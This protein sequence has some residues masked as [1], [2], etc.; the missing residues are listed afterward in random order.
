MAGGHNWLACGR[1]FLVC[2]GGRET[3][4]P[5]DLRGFP[6]VP[7]A[8]VP[9]PQPSAPGSVSR[10]PSRRAQPLQASSFATFPSQGT[11][12]CRQGSLLHTL[13]QA[14]LCFREIHPRN[15]ESSP[16]CRA[17]G[18]LGRRLEQMCFLASV[19]GSPLPRRM[20]GGALAENPRTVARGSGPPL[21]PARIR[22]QRASRAVR[23][24]A[25]RPLPQACGI[26]WN[27]VY[28]GSAGAQA[29]HRAWPG[30]ALPGG[31]HLGSGWGV[32]AQGSGGEEGRDAGGLPASPSHL[33]SGSIS[34]NT[35]TSCQDKGLLSGF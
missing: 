26:G 32:A 12:P 5:A 10:G 28:G 3:V 30:C 33:P 6:S 29:A 34:A 4:V 7:P 18:L 14:G 20:P 8:G 23:S 22:G 35:T 31:R 15:P 19:Q 25:E 17:H 24:G 13:P 27:G 16:G 2:F 1:Y 21:P 11:R 9:G